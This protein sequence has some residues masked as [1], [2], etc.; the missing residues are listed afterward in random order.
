MPEFSAPVPVCANSAVFQESHCSPVTALS[1]NSV[2]AECTNVF[3]TI[4]KNQVGSVAS[5]DNTQ[6]LP[7]E[8]RLLDQCLAMQATIY[9]DLHMGNYIGVIVQYTNIETEH[10]TGGVSASPKAWSCP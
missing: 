5:E 10:S 2:D 6:L 8:G 3:A 1:F 4:G 9:D 7:Q